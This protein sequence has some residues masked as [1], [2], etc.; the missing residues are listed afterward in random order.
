MAL[1]PTFLNC[2]VHIGA[3]LSPELC[4]QVIYFLK[5]NQYCFAWSHEDMARISPYVS[6]H[7][8]NINPEHKPVNEN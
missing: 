4:N 3:T 7:K 2:A 1:D 8:L 5:A 6:T